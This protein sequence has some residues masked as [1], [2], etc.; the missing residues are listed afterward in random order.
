ML[1][2]IHIYSY[3]AKFNVLLF[4][5]AIPVLIFGSFVRLHYITLSNSVHIVYRVSKW[6]IVW[7]SCKNVIVHKKV[8]CGWLSISGNASRS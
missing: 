7:F 1:M 4:A 3:K 6:D 8:F 5:C 2:Q